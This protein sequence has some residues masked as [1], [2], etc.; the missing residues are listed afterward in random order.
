MASMTINRPL[1]NVIRE[2]AVSVVSADYEP[3]RPFFVRATTGGSI[4]YWP[5]G[6]ED[7]EPITKVIEDSALFTDPVIA[8]KIKKQVVT[9]PATSYASGIYVGFA[10]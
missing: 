8:R 9:S 1:T 5:A 4:T 7:N 3:G 6:N 10:I 2:V